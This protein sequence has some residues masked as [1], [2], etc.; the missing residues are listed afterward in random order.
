MKRNMLSLAAILVI[1][2]LTLAVRPGQTDEPRTTA[3]RAVTLLAR[4]AVNQPGAA[5]SKDPSARPRPR[6]LPSYYGQVGLSDPQRERIYR[7]QAAY[8]DRIDEL[9]KQL[10]SLKAKRDQEIEAVL[11]PPQKERLRHLVEAAAKRRAARSG[12]TAANSVDKDKQ[13]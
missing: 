4:A 7:L 6:R 9:E 10:E 13:P 5:Q 12:T 2:M 3:I 8:A 11:T 1:A